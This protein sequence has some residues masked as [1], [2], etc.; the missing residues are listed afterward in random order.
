M[1]SKLKPDVAALV[2]TF[3]DVTR[4]TKWRRWY[5]RGGGWEW[6][7]GEQ[8]PSCVVHCTYIWSSVQRIQN[9]RKGN[10]FVEVITTQSTA[11]NT[12]FTT[13]YTVDFIDIRFYCSSVWLSG[14]VVRSRLVVSNTT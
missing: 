11:Q 5:C 6:W 10:R 12:S 8:P 2:D 13:F 4:H 3:S 7:G 9:N 14:I 1:F